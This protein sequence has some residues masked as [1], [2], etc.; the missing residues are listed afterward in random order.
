[1]SLTI[2][3]LGYRVKFSRRD[4]D[5]YDNIC[6]ALRKNAPSELKA[7]LKE[8]TEDE[9]SDLVVEILLEIDSRLE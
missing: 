6:Y 2:E 4:Y 7:L 5:E 1:M 9:F 3:V 8:M